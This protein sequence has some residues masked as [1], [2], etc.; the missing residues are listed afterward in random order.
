[1][2][3]LITPLKNLTWFYLSK[4]YN[5]SSSRFNYIIPFLFHKIGKEI[6]A[7]AEPF[8]TFSFN[9]LILSLIILFCFI[10]IIGYF[11]SIY[12]VNKY[13]IESKYPK[14][15]KYIRYFEKSRIYFVLVEILLCFFCII[16][17][18]LSN[19]ILLSIFIFK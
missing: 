4:I 16:T 18:L 3:K 12:L 10:N 11:T 14:Y 7:D 17:I 9:T 6:P 13:N 2:F 8:V 19:F 1:M 15:A 5:A